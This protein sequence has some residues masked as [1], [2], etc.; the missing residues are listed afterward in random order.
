MHGPSCIVPS[1]AGVRLPGELERRG[2]EEEVLRAQLQA[3]AH[4][5]EEETHHRIDAAYKDASAA[6]SKAL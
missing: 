3:A 2:Q 4:Q 5:A 6:V 1:G